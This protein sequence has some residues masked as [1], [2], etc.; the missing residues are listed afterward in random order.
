ME[1]ARKIVRSKGEG[2]GEGV[3]ARLGAAG[4]RG[5]FW[6]DGK[7]AKSTFGVAWQLARAIGGEVWR[8]GGSATQN[9]A[10]HLL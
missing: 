4:G 8:G 5:R 3:S 10:K 6:D 9:I 1:V 2:C 7:R